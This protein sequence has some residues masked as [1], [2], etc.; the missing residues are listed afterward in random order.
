MATPFEIWA[1]KAII[2]T[3]FCEETCLAARGGATAGARYFYF[4]NSGFETAA[5]ARSLPARPVEIQPPSEPRVSGHVTASQLD[6]E[7][8]VHSVLS[9]CSAFEEL[10][11]SSG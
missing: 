1:G 9:L 4:D 8:D 6:N 11:N 7:S 3:L 10:G 5:S 2:A